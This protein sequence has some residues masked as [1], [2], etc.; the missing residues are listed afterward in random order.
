[1]DAPATMLS[2]SGKTNADG[3]LTMRI[4]VPISE[5]LNDAIIALAT[6]DGVSKAEWLRNLAEEKV[7]GRLCMVRRVTRGHGSR[8]SEEYPNGDRN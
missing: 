1:M 2:R 7:F 5:E 4:D 3:K 8:E 6:I